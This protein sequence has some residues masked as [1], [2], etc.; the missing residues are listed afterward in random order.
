MVF[1]AFLP[2]VG[3]AAIAADAFAGERERRTLDTLLSSPVEER[4][5][6]VGKAAA[7]VVFGVT[8]GAVGL[9]L[10]NRE[11][12]RRA[13]PLC[14]VAF[15]RGRRARRV[16]RVGA[17]HVG[18]RHRRVDAGAGRARVAADRLHLLGALSLR[19]GSLLEA[20][21][22]DHT[23]R[24][25]MIASGFVAVLAFAVLELAIATFR[26]EQFFKER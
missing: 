26:R 17:A 22:I 25:A 19:G 3:A 10:G 6:L 16:V 13:R 8:I 18:R 9:P 20:N 14:S 2:G 21:R 5:I 11:H 15:C 24:A 7:A 23:W 1:F 12:Q 4:T